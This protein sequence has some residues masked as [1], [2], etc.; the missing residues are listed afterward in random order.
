MT[1]ST[2]HDPLRTYK[3]VDVDGY[4]HQI[5]AHRYNQVLL[6]VGGGPSSLSIGLN[7]RGTGDTLAK[8][9]VE[10]R[11][12]AD[13]ISPLAREVASFT[14]PRYVVDQGER[15]P[16]QNIVVTVSLA[17]GPNPEL[18]LDAVETAIT[19]SLSPHYDATVTSGIVPA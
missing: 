6:T 18:R 12:D 19:R 1:R 2:K 4:T 9:W 16:D 3:V 11:E 7:S 15:E 8:F 5:E 13:D 17:A 14:N 10:T